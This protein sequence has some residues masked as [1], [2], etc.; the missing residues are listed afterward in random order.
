[1]QPTGKKTASNFTHSSKLATSAASSGS[2]ARISL[3]E[4]LQRA[5]D[6]YKKEGRHK[7]ILFIQEKNLPGFAAIIK[8]RISSECYAFDK[9]MANLSRINH[10]Y[11]PE[12]LFAHNLVFGRHDNEQGR[13][14]VAERN[15]TKFCFIGFQD[16]IVSENSEIPIYGTGA[17]SKIEIDD[18]NKNLFFRTITLIDDEPIESHRRRRNITCQLHECYDV[19][20]DRSDI[21]QLF[22]YSTETPTRKA[23]GAPPKFSDEELFSALN[24]A[25]P[26]TPPFP[27]VSELMKVLD[28]FCAKYA[29]PPVDKTLRRK[30]KKWLDMQ[31]AAKK[32]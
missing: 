9:S 7:L 30:A 8:T 22:P 20:F 4:V 3:R 16:K 13:Y 11:T 5:K 27:E 1:M 12:E 29:D 2:S 31:S 21:D 25:F 17:H 18:S 14:E 10:R 28:Q 15:D 32:T 6:V 23:R 24:H 26:R 19:S